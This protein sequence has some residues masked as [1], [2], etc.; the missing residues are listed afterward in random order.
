VVLFAREDSLHS[1]KQAR[2]KDGPKVLRVCDFIAE[3][4]N[5]R[6]E[7]L[8]VRGRLKKERGTLEDD[9]LVG[10]LL[11]HSTE[12]VLVREDDGDGCGLSEVD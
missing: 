11:D 4:I 1:E 7:G 5:S 12:F 3:D 8:V 10:L 9:V 2:S 6:P